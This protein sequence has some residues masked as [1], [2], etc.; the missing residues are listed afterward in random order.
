MAESSHGRS[1]RRSG[2]ELP[3]MSPADAARPSELQPRAGVALRRMLA[4]NSSGGPLNLHE[5]AIVYWSEAEHFA[6][7]SKPDNKQIFLR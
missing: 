7:V 3:V 2:T 1:Q 6:L 5:V 4:R